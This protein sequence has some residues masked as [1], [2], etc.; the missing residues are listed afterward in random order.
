MSVILQLFGGFP[1]NYPNDQL[2]IP[3]R[4]E[5]W[6]APKPFKN[7]KY[8]CDLCEKS[9]KALKTLLYFRLCGFN[10]LLLESP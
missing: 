10:Q 4:F 6:A 1:R 2:P 8:H 3:F 5:G 7:N 9:A